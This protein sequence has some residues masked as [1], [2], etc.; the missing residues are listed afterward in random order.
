[1]SVLKGD[2][3][4]RGTNGSMYNSF[5]RS[6]TLGKNDAKGSKGDIGPRGEKGSKGD[7]D[8]RIFTVGTFLIIFLLE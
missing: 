3:G 4:I 2:R 1:M 8:P 6:P 5:T 7:V